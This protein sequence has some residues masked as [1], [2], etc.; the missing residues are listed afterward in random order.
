MATAVYYDTDKA[1]PSAAVP[2]D[3]KSPGALIAKRVSKDSDQEE[4]VEDNF[5]EVS[6]I[7][8]LDRISISEQISPSPRK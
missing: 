6:V 8:T 4:T 2:S 1:F 3:S 7:Q 5:K